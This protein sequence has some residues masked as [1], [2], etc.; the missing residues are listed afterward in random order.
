M[1]SLASSQDNGDGWYLQGDP[2]ITKDE[3]IDLPPCYIDKT[4]TVTNGEGHDSV[5][6]SA[7]CFKERSGTH[8]SDV[9]WTQPPDY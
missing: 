9:T 6:W 2:V 4:I 7:D 1:S 8:S 5:K 3:E